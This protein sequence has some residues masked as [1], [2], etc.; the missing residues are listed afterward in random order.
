LAG[1]FATSVIT[2]TLVSSET[3][4]ANGTKRQFY[5]ANPKGILILDAAGRYA[6]VQGSANRAKFRNP[7]RFQVTPEE[8]GKAALEYAANFG[9][10]SINEADK[11]LTR[12][13]ESALTPN[14]EGTE[15]KYSVSLAGDELKLSNTNTVTGDRGDVVYRRAR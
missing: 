10:W 3:T 8:M 6:A 7:S 11:T 14:N 2:W 9:T 5:G 1:T 13:Y 12:R 15:Q 4:A